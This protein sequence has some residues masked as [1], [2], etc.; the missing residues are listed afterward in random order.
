VYITAEFGD[1][2]RP[3]LDVPVPKLLGI[4][5]LNKFT[6]LVSCRGLVIHSARNEKYKVESYFFIK[7]VKSIRHTEKF[8]YVHMRDVRLVTKGRHIEKQAQNKNFT[9]LISFT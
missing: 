2:S 9:F 7:C 3:S 6:L 8:I 5:N 1:R 4:W